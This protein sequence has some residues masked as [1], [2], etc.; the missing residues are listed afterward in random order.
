MHYISPI[1]NS[2]INLLYL[3]ISLTFANMIQATHYS[4]STSV[5]TS[6]Q[7][8]SIASYTNTLAATFDRT[9]AS[10]IRWSKRLIE[11]VCYTLISQEPKARTETV[12]RF[13]SPS[14]TDWNGLSLH[15]MKETFHFITQRNVVVPMAP[16]FKLGA[17]F[18]GKA[19]REHHRKM[20]AFVCFPQIAIKFVKHAISSFWEIHIAPC[21]LNKRDSAG[22]SAIEKKMLIT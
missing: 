1:A 7:F 6:N 14:A 19:L 8:V 13:K 15:W 18:C 12:F 2:F 9:P 4:Y 3:Q 10:H 20:C 11:N 16:C 22:M 5:T 17:V 21:F